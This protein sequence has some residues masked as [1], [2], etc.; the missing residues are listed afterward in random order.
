MDVPLDCVHVSSHLPLRTLPLPLSL[1][2]HLKHVQLSTSCPSKLMGTR[3]SFES[4][5][6]SL[7]G[8]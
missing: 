4:F 3:T 8:G 2:L 1:P 7:K 5:P 6:Q